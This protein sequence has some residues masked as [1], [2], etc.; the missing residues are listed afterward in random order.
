M[1]ILE[2]FKFLGMCMVPQLFIFLTVGL[3]RN[4]VVQECRALKNTVNFT[5]TVNACF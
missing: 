4:A 3:F 2:D 5:H 1:S